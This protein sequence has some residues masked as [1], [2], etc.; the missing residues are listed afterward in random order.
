MPRKLTIG[1]IT[2]GIVAATMLL[3]DMIIG[4]IPGLAGLSAPAQTAI[5]VGLVV[6]IASIATSFAL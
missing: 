6:A 1:L 2:G 3:V 5:R 4:F